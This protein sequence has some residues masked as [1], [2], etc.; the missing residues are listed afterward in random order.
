[1]VVHLFVGHSDRRVVVQPL[2]HKLQGQRVLGAAGLLDLGPFVLEPYL[3]L[4]FVQTKLVGQFL[5]SALRQVSVLVELLLQ[6]GQLF[7]A[8]RGP[9]P[10]LLRTLVLPLHP[11][12]S[13][14]WKYFGKSTIII[15][16]NEHKLYN[17]M[18]LMCIASRYVVEWVGGCRWFLKNGYKRRNIIIMSLFAWL[19]DLAIKVIKIL[20]TTEQSSISFKSSIHV[21]ARY[22][23]FFYHFNYFV[24]YFINAYYMF[25]STRWFLRYTP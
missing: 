7:T 15:W 25:W 11:P 17:N 22:M 14:S 2:R 21:S 18:L 5:A 9:G 10:L 6:S 20:I 24:Q 1:M 13:G 16:R 19:S 23:L 12:R 4:G 3:Y 8:K